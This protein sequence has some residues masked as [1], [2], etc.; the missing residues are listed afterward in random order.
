MATSTTVRKGWIKRYKVKKF[1]RGVRQSKFFKMWT[2]E[3]RVI[4]STDHSRKKS[5]NNESILKKVRNNE[6]HIF[7][8]QTSRPR[9]YNQDSVLFFC[10]FF[11]QLC[12]RGRDLQFAFL[13]LY[14]STTDN[15]SSFFFHFCCWAAEDEQCFFFF[16][17][18][19][20]L[21]AY[22]QRGIKIKLPQV[23]EQRK[24]FPSTLGCS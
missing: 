20:L 6:I 7:V 14:Y 13:T 2:A 11:S 4:T 18:C 1:Q 5:Q 12:F 9:R 10:F 22:I 23:W 15:W 24:P 16:F 8:L 19:V 17:M 3:Q 21:F